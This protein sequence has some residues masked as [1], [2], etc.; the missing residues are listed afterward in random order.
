MSA[1]EVNYFNGSAP[2]R[3]RYVLIHSSRSALSLTRLWH[4][5]LI[6]RSSGKIFG[7]SLEEGKDDTVPFF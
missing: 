1:Y 2:I 3:F 7:C 6:G 4:E 5:S